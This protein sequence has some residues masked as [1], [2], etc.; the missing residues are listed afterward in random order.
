MADREGFGGVAPYHGDQARCRRQ[1]EDF[2]R[3]GFRYDDK[4]AS[5]EQEALLFDDTGLNDAEKDSAQIYETTAL[6]IAG[7]QKDTYY[8]SLGGAGAPTA[9]AS[10]RRSS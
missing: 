6:A 10:T 7:N 1:Q 4:G 5:K 2:G 8:G 3:H 9:P